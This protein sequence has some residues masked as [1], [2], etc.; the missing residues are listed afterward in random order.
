M[1]FKD[2]SAVFSSPSYLEV[3]F[4]KLWYSIPDQLIAFW[5]FILWLGSFLFILQI[6]FKQW[7]S[8]WFLWQLPCGI[9]LFQRMWVPTLSFP[10][11]S[12]VT[13]SRPFTIWRQTT[14][15]MHFFFPANWNLCWAPFFSV[16]ANSAYVHPTYQ[17]Y[18]NK[19]HLFHE[20]CLSFSLS[21]F[22][23]LTDLSFK[24]PIYYTSK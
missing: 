5:T 4:W 3:L 19:F 1:A 20:A 16:G 15:F 18:I 23:L 11:Y 13:I 7:F 6:P 9:F 17:N 12:S 8:F 24:I 10:S 2:T 22:K 21:S 14:F